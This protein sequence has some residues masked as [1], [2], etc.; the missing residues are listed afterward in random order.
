L[1]QQRC[2]PVCRRH[3]EL[4]VTQAVG[5]IGL[6]EGNGAAVGPSVGVAENPGAPEYWWAYALLLSTMIPSL[7]N[8]AIGGM[9]F[10]R[11]IPGVGRLLLHW[12]PEG[13][14]VPDYRRPLADDWLD[15]PNVFGRCPRHRRAGF[16]CL[17]APLPYHA[18]RR[19]RFALALPTT[20]RTRSTRKLLSPHRHHPLGHSARRR[21]FR[22]ARKAFHSV[23]LTLK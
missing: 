14:D 3:G 21:G 1:E 8:L 6:G 16:S 2:L 9:A 10:T 17:G 15:V 11:G 18:R 23:P 19:P 5:G 22:L 12:I 20:R 13:R 7:I 4:V